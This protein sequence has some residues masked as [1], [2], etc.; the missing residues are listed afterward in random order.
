MAR[1]SAWT[2]CDS[3]VRVLYRPLLYSGETMFCETTRPGDKKGVRMSELFLEY[4]TAGHLLRTIAAAIRSI[5]KSSG[6]ATKEVAKTIE[7][8]GALRA[9][10]VTRWIKRTPRRRSSSDNDTQ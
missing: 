10:D 6:S 9:A 3:A 7:D 8:L 1:D 5:S 2:P 4:G